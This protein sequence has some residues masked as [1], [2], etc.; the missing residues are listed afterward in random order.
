MNG[1]TFTQRFPLFFSSPNKLTCDYHVNC[2]R[3]FWHASK[4]Q[5]VRALQ[6]PCSSGLLNQKEVRRTTSGYAALGAS[7]GSKKGTTRRVSSAQK[8]SPLHNLDDPSLHD[9]AFRN[10]IHTHIV[11]TLAVVA[12]M[13]GLSL[14]FYGERCL[15]TTVGADYAH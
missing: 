2:P 4:Y 15:K 5:T 13:G 3:Y 1:R 6:A 11:A 12:L 14:S 8:R 10:Y 9:Y 7:G